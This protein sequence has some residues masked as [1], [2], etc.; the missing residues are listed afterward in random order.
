[1]TDKSVATKKPRQ[2]NSPAQSYAIHRLLLLA[3]QEKIAAAR[4]R[5]R[6]RRTSQA[7]PRWRR[8]RCLSSGG[9]GP[10]PPSA[11]A[12]PH[13]RRVAYS[14]PFA[15]PLPPAVMPAPRSCSR[16]W[17]TR[18]SRYGSLST[19]YLVHRVLVCACV[20]A[21]LALVCPE[22]GAGEGV[23]A[24]TGHDVVEVYLW[25]QRLGALP[26]GASW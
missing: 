9:A 24:G 3:S 22:L 1:M 7:S 2:K 16:R 10:P 4:G 26:R 14:P 23:P 19:A 12:P 11:P 8:R 18:N 21:D 20:C 6:Q 5:S 25:E 13:P 17:T 15:G